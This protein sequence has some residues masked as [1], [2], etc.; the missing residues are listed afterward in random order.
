MSASPIILIAITTKE[1]V[2]DLDCVKYLPDIS[3]DFSISC[4]LDAF[5]ATNK[6]L[7]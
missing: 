3:S 4:W 2:T 6:S 7:R 5:L 1:E